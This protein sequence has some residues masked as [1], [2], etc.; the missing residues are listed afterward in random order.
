MNKFYR[1]PTEGSDRDIW[2]R[3]ELPQN[4]RAL[5]YIST[6]IYDDSG[7]LKVRKG[8]IGY[9][10]G[11]I[12][13]AIEID[14]ITTIS[15]AGVTNGYWA[16]VEVEID[17]TTVTFT[18]TELNG[19]TD[20]SSLPALF[21]NSTYYDTEKGCYYAEPTK[22]LVGL[23]WKNSSGTLEGIVNCLENECYKGYSLS[24][25]AL[26]Q[27][28]RWEKLVN[29]TVDS[30][31]IGRLHIIP[32][33]ERPG[34]W[35]LSSGSSLT[36]ADVDFSAY[37]PKGVT[38]L[39]LKFEVGF[40]GDGALDTGVAYFRP[41]GSSETSTIK[42]TQVENYRTNYTAADWID[43]GQNITLLCDEDGIIEY[44]VN[45]ADCDLWLNIVGYYLPENRY[46]E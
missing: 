28:Y 30:N 37:V 45:D 35:I 23:I 33:D 41:N 6:F 38:A 12:K 2:H 24:D 14:T 43:N 42:L 16:K 32:E 36:F 1:E 22:R 4:R 3:Y 19:E 34:S 21:E 39:L 5:N 11:S 8:T 17:G 27:L 7:T 15:L 31:Y 9:D 13:G 25:D 10:N 29:N 46:P 18:A 20:P 26:D 40:T 44:Y